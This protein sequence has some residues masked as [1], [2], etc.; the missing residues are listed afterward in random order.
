MNRFLLPYM[1]VYMSYRGVLPILLHLIGW[2]YYAEIIY[3]N[4]YLESSQID[5]CISTT[6]SLPS[7]IYILCGENR[8]T[9]KSCWFEM[10]SFEVMAT[11]YQYIY[12]Y[13]KLFQKLMSICMASCA[14]KNITWYLCA[15]IYEAPTYTYR[16]QRNSLCCTLFSAS[17][18]TIFIR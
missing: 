12:G 3:Y 9:V 8:F 16:F 15:I 13:S 7:Y 11:E 10:P 18:V 6:L 5:G 14:N 4:Y 1:Y 2:F 17:F